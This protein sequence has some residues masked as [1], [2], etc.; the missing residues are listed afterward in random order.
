MENYYPAL[1][2]PDT[3][4]NDNDHIMVKIPLH[5]EKELVSINAMIYSRATADFIDREVCKQHGINMI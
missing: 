3:L 5:G 2:Y 4:E 1:N